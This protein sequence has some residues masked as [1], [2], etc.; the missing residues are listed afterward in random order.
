MQLKLPYFVVISIS[1]CLIHRHYSNGFQWIQVLWVSSTVLLELLLSPSLGPD[2]YATVSFKIYCCF[3]VPF[4]LVSKTK[5]YIFFKEAVRSCWKV[6][7]SFH[8]PPPC[9]PKKKKSANSECKSEVS[10]RKGSFKWLAPLYLQVIQPDLN[11]V[12]YDYYSQGMRISLRCPG[13]S[14]EGA[15]GI[16]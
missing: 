15:R 9:P 3:L 16:P 8:T 14:A 6:R 2:F 13:N 12:R 1:V 11:C 10:Q 5:P 7:I 4:C